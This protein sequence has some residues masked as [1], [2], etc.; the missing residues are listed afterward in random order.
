[1]RATLSLEDDAF[2]AAQACSRACCLEQVQALFELFRLG[3]V[4]RLPMQNQDG[5]WVFELPTD[6]PKVSAERRKDEL[7]EVS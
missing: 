6:K 5:T 1:M 2:A 4:E 3:S 7:D